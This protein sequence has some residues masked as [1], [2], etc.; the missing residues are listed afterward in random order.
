MFFHNNTEYFIEGSVTLCHTNW[1]HF[2][3]MARLSD[4]PKG[5]RSFLASGPITTWIGIAMPELAKYTWLHLCNYLGQ[6][7]NCVPNM[8]FNLR[9]NLEGSAEY[10][11]ITLEEAKILSQYCDEKDALKFKYLLFHLGIVDKWKQEADKLVKII[12]GG[13]D[14]VNLYKEE[15]ER[16]VLHLSE[17]EKQ[18]MEKYFG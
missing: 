9:Q 17:A 13:K 6:P 1:S 18:E 16:F 10:F 2:S 3:F 5:R 14:F 7:L 12:Y 8:Q 4:Y 15:D 11:N